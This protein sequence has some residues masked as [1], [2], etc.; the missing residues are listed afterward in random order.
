[1]AQ[2]ENEQ[3]KSDKPDD[4]D[5]GVHIP[6]SHRPFVGTTNPTGSNSDDKKDNNAEGEP[7]KPSILSP[8]HRNVIKPLNDIKLDEPDQEFNPPAALAPAKEKKVDDSPK[9]MDTKPPVKKETSPP[10]P[11]NDAATTSN[12]NP[13]D[14]ATDQ[15]P[16]SNEITAVLDGNDDKEKE[17]ENKDDEKR[18]QEIESVIE[19]HKYYVPVYAV[20]RR[21]SIKV[22]FGLLAV[23]LVLAMVLIDL[24]LDSGTI[25]LV[26]KVPHTHFFNISS[27]QKN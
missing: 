9:Y 11:T 16:K 14:I 22:N 24:M 3:H 8:S 4:Q 13:S 25:L 2:E 10:T 27:S 21:Q 23:V 12:S 18:K 26:Q 20:A 6:I 1:M 5:A 17:A 15:P 19:S 7:S